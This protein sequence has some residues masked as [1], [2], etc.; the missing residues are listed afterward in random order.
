MSETQP[1]LTETESVDSRVLAYRA[2]QERIE[3]ASR[4]AC[5]SVSSLNYLTQD[6][7]PPRVTPMR[8][9]TTSENDF[10][11]PL[12]NAELA[13][14]RSACAHCNEPPKMRRTG[15]P[16]RTESSYRGHVKRKLGTQSISE[17]VIVA[18]RLN[19]LTAEDIATA[20][21]LEFLGR[22]TH[23]EREVFR[24][25]AQ[26]W[27]PKEIAGD[28]RRSLK[29]VETHTFQLMRRLEVHCRLSLTLLWL[30]LQRA[31]RTQ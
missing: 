29:T 10:G 12:T 30:S 11:A 27:S 3:F 17:S 23:R 21:P 8:D 5:L 20:T 25:L 2:A 6:D 1:P 31:A 28:T 16:A 26:G 4:I 22:L 19:L 18:Y 9:K 24:K 14:L 7:P 13:Y 15:I